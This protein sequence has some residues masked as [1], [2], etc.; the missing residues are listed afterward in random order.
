MPRAVKVA[1]WYDVKHVVSEVLYEGRSQ[2]KTD[3]GAHSIEYKIMYTIRKYME[4]LMQIL[5][6]VCF[7]M[8]HVHQQKPA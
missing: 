1:T 3:P 4:N 6:N 2:L 7:T 8:V 5:A